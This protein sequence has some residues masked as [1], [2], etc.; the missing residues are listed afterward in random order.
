MNC[1]RVEIGGAT[2]WPSAYDQD[3]DSGEPKHA[4]LAHGYMDNAHMTRGPDGG[5]RALC[6]PKI[7]FFNYMLKILIDF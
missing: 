5:G 7:W 6:F 4:S 3:P 1:M 2:I